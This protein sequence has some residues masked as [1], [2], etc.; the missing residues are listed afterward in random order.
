MS[1][2]GR[3]LG[4]GL[5]APDVTRSVVIPQDLAATLTASGMPLAEAVGA[6]LRGYLATGSAATNEDERVPFWLARDREH[7]T[8]I[9]G[10]LLD[11]MAQRGATEGGDALQLELA[12]GAE[13]KG[14]ASDAG[15]KAARGSTSGGGPKTADD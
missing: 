4:R 11:R 14:R 15:P 2:L 6:A 12:P 13:V 3:L 1:W 7:A 8:D 9:E 5:E 10:R